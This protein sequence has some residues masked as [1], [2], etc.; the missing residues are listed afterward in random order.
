MPPDPDSGAAGTEWQT[1]RALRA[2]GHEVDELWAADLGRRIRHGNL[3]YLLE[4]PYRYR[5]V[6]GERCRKKSYDAIHANQGHCYLAASQHRRERRSGVF[7]CR[8][9]GLDDHMEYVLKPWR[10]KLGIRDRSGAK[11]VIGPSLDRLLHRHDR[12]AY[13]GAD[14]ILVSSSIDEAYL[15]DVMHVPARRIGRIAQAP[16]EAF[17]ASPA[18]PM[19]GQRIKRLLHVGGFAYWKGVH[20]VASA[21]NLLA[22]RQSDWR[23]TW[24]CRAQE[25]AKVLQLLDSAAQARI[26]LVAWLPQQELSSIYDCHGIFLS[27]SLFEGFGKVFLE[28]M[29]RGLCVIGTPAGGMPD[30]IEDGASGQLVPFNEPVDIVQNIERLWENPALAMAMSGRASARARE[31]SWDRVAVETAAFYQRLLDLRGQQGSPT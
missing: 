26:D 18:P 16:A 31:Y 27:P 19:G 30:V 13:R 1:I 21:M 28:A 25:H 23:M 3:H 5:S 15:R 17:M 14:G 6:I 4:L 24:V 9:H 22:V 2:R 10:T 11:A 8:S 7:I 20:A 29:A 12:L